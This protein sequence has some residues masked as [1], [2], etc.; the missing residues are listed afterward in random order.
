MYSDKDY[1][2]KRNCQNSDG[3][4]HVLCC[5]TLQ[6]GLRPQ[7]ISGHKV[8]FED[9]YSEDLLKQNEETT[10]FQLLL[11]VGER[12]LNSPAAEAGP[13]H[14]GDTLAKLDLH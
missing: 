6:D 2:V 7:I 1:P 10:I 4:Q 11:E 8:V 14:F 3:S 12:I 5:Q 13:L 9:V